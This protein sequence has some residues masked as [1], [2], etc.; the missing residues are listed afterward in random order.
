MH[1]I[2]YVQPS[3]ECLSKGTIYTPLG[4][5]WVANSSQVFLDP[6]NCATQVDVEAIRTRAQINCTIYSANKNAKHYS[7]IC[8][9]G[10]NRSQ[11]HA[12]FVRE[13]LLNISFVGFNENDTS[14]KRKFASGL[15]KVE[16]GKVTTRS[17]R[18]KL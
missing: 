3:V 18:T 7:V 12:S 2:S 1:R 15:F 9:Q 4:V 10:R 17:K 5:P 6:G 11:C 16:E 14:F 13:I 8:R